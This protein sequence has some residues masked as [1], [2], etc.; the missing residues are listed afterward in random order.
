MG[1]MKLLRQLRAWWK[2]MKRA[3]NAAV[4]WEID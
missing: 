3:S 2:A 1:A 4:R